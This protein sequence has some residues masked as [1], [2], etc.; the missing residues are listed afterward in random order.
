MYKAPQKRLPY[1]LT[2]SGLLPF[3]QRVLRGDVATSYPV[4]SVSQDVLMYVLFACKL[5]TLM[6]LSM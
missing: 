5:G 3:F 1:V 6:H 2:C 4:Y